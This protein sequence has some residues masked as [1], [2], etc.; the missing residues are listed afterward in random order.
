M[1]YIYKYI[2][3]SRWIFLYN[4]HCNMEQ[5]YFVIY[6]DL[7]TIFCTVVWILRFPTWRPP[8]IIIWCAEK[9]GKSSSSTFSAPNSSQCDGRKAIR[10]PILLAGLWL[11][12][13]KSVLDDFFLQQKE[14]LNASSTAGV[15]NWKSTLSFLTNPNQG[16]Q[17]LSWAC[18]NIRTVS[19][20]SIFMMLAIHWQGWLMHCRYECQLGC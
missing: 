14:S 16:Q 1:Y 8:G 5:H 18:P 7:C 19:L 11:Q 13:G 15:R 9:H 4:I 10:E 2:Q 6:W 3:W 17:Q 12:P 20:V